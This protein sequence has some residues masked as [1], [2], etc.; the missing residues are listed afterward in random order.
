MDGLNGSFRVCVVRG[1]SGVGLGN[2][3]LKIGPVVAGPDGPRSRVDGPVV[4]R[5]VDLPL[6]CVGSCGCLG[7]VSI[8]IS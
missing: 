6:I 3:F 1:G 5:L 7:Y 2:P 8:G 4:C